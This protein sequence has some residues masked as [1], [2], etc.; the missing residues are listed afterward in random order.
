MKIKIYAIILTLSLIWGCKEV[1]P[2]F[3]IYPREVKTDTSIAGEQRTYHFKIFNKG[4]KDLIIEDYVV[5][6]EC[7]QINLSRGKSVSSNDSIPLS[8]KI[9]TKKEDSNKFKEVQCT[10]KTNAKP[11]FYNIALK[12]YTK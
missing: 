5:G 8:I 2:I 4:R 1:K 11:T 3:E 7:T 12:F 9:S 6:C 10:F